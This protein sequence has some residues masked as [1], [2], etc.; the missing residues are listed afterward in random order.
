MKIKVIQGEPIL[1]VDNDNFGLHRDRCPDT[2][3]G[4]LRRSNMN[5][6]GNMTNT[7][8]VELEGEIKTRLLEDL[9]YAYGNDTKKFHDKLVEFKIIKEQQPVDPAKGYLRK[10]KDRDGYK[11]ESYYCECGCK[12]TYWHYIK[13]KSK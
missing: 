8:K 7:K 10:P 4:Q 5:D 1:D 12:R 2:D 9:A 6:E 11:I 13:I 3:W